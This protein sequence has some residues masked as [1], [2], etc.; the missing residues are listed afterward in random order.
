M[1]QTDEANGVV[2]DPG[3]IAV[4]IIS[5]SQWSRHR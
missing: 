5:L 2:K 3:G 4:E 1:I